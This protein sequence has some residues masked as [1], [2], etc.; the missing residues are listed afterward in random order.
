MSFF[1]HQKTDVSSKSNTK[2]RELKEPM[3]LQN[4]KQSKKGFF[5]RVLNGMK[6]KLI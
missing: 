4:Q 2:Q 6:K 1:L 3:F 5:L